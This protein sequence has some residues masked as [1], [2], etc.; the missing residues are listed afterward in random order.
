[1]PVMDGLTAS[2]IITTRIKNS[3]KPTATSIVAVTAYTGQDIEEEC[4]RVN[5]EQMLNKPVDIAELISV[6]QKHFF[7]R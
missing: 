4:K 3:S 2:K 5:M 7:M 1:M 6:M